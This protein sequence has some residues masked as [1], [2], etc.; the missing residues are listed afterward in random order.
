ML[1]SPIRIPRVRQDRAHHVNHAHHKHLVHASAASASASASASTTSQ[2]PTPSSTG[3]KSIAKYLEKCPIERLRTIYTNA[4]CART[5][6]DVPEPSV[7]II[8]FQEINI[9]K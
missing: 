6:H 4:A 3:D 1:T 5:R 7:K 9:H 8:G 2:I